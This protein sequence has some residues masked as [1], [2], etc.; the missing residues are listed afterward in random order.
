MN[1]ILPLA[2]RFL[3]IALIIGFLLKI[4]GNDAPFLINISLAGLGI[5]FFLNIY[6]PIHSK[7][8]ENEQPDENKLNGLNELLSKYIVP[9]VIWIGSAVATVGL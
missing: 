2:E 6:L 5:V 7:A 4:S 8:E 9:K 1:K 3:V